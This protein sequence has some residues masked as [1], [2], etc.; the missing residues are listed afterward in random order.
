V[1]FE[2]YF[3]QKK[4]IAEKL[5][6]G[7]LPQWH[8]SLANI[9]SHL[10]S[11]RPRP[12]LCDSWIFIRGSHG[13]SSVFSQ[14]QAFIMWLLNIHQRI[15]GISSWYS[16]AISMWLLHIHRRITWYLIFILSGPGHHYVTVEYSSEYCGNLIF[17]LSG[18]GRHYVTVEYSSE[19]CMES[20]LGTLRPRP[21]LCDCWIFIRWSHG[22][23][24]WF[25]RAPVVIMWLLNIHRRFSD[26]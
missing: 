12:S 15:T 22:I 10:G 11:L 19:D 3:Q 4:T 14:V 7:C 21:S 25:S 6:N 17:V 9:P 5:P 23:S 16:Q 26:V 13:I 8:T 1:R 2:A 20:H 18:P 24:S